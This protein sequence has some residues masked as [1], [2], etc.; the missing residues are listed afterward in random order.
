MP[1]MARPEKLHKPDFSSREQFFFRLNTT[2]HFLTRLEDRWNKNPPG[3]DQRLLEFNQYKLDHLNKMKQIMPLGE[4]EE[5][6]IYDV[7][8]MFSF[9]HRVTSKDRVIAEAQEQPR[10]GKI[11]GC[12]GPLGVGKTTTATTL[13][14]DFGVGLATVEPFDKN[15]AWRA[16]QENP[17]QYAEYML[18]SQVYFFLSN[19]NADI[20]SDIKSRQNSET[21]ISDTSILTDILMWVDWY[22]Q[23]GKFDEKEYQIYKKLVEMF[24]PV[25]PRPDLLVVLNSDTSAHLKTG[26][27][28]RRE[29]DPK[30]SGELFTE[31]E[32][33]IQMK[34]TD[35]LAGY[36]EGEGVST[37]RMTV[38]PPDLWENPHIS[39]DI[40]Y[41][42][43]S[44]LGLLGEF[45][46]PKPEDIVDQAL[47]ILSP[48]GEGKIIII[49]SKSMFS[50]KTTAVCLLADKVGVDKVLAFQPA[51]AL[52]NQEDQFKDQEGA[53][54]S[55]DNL[56][57]AAH[58]IRD[59]NVNSIYE[60]IKR[61]KISPKDKPYIFIDEMMLFTAHDRSPREVINVLEVLRRMGFH[62][63]VDGIDYTFQEQ[64]FTFMH[65]L[66]K[67]VLKDENGNWH[68]IETKT[69]CRFCDKDAQGTRLTLVEKNGNRSI[70]HED[71]GWDHPGSLDFDPVCCSDAHPSCI[72]KNPDQFVRHELP[73]AI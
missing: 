63:V 7:F 30:R 15:A 5:L 23:T 1:N 2:L 72:H 53:I 42:L 40:I 54:I 59:N 25:I 61:K 17:D 24:M 19:L 55:R 51:A 33:A 37:L 28:K 14:T 27:D 11:I 66:I 71:F 31:E 26:I 62:I 10:Q 21:Q 67:R 4:A 22:H 65:G 46:K 38:N 32:L 29:S 73:T 34:I 50:G 18:R 12:L 70:A 56:R 13:A 58:L 20:R 6:L 49:H 52:R 47:K 41:Q 69:R 3:N 57:I 35:R 44:K 60:F 48:A 45:L 43:R 36:L 68:Q 16:Q 64:P 39:Y 9:K 8:D